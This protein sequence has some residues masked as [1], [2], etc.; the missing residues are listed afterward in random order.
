MIGG[1]RL[2]GRLPGLTRETFLSASVGGERLARI[3]ALIAASSRAPLLDLGRLKADL[4]VPAGPC[5]AVLVLG[6]ADDNV[7]DAEGV[8]SLAR[9][10]GVEPVVIDGIAHDVMLDAEWEAA[11]GAVLRWLSGLRR[12]GEA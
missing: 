3:N 1:G 5:P 12:A 2:F 8:A 4:P 7:V 10:Y 9:A 6:A 11:A